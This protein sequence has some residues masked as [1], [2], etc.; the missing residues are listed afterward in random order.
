MK[1]IVLAV[2]SIALASAVVFAEP[3]RESVV[4]IGFEVSQITYEEPGL[5]EQEG[6]MYGVSASY[7][8]LRSRKMIKLDTRASFGQVDYTSP[9]SGTIDDIDDFNIETRVT[10]GYDYAPYEKMILTPY[11]GFGHRYLNDDMSGLTSSTGA[12]GYERESNYLYSPIG[13]DAVVNFKS[14]WS[15]GAVAEY[16]LFWYGMQRSHLEDVNM[17]LSTM[18]NDQTGGWGARGSFIIKKNTEKI[19]FVI[20]PFVRYWDIDKSD[21]TTLTYYGF[22]VGKG[23]EP[24]NNSTEYGIKLAVQF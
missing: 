18:D 14:G 15:I 21:E 5:M 20:E 19:N 8:F 17:G 22:V 4:E 6:M 2:I 7:D 11:V 16:D 23:Y 24:E 3:V 10:L 9:I 13:V 1:A 12:A